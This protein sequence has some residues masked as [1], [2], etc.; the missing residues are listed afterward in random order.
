MKKKSKSKFNV[1]LLGLMFLL[2]AQ[3]TNAT[4]RR[5]HH[6]HHHPLPV[7]NPQPEPSPQP[8]SSPQPAVQPSNNIQC[9]IQD[10]G[11]I[12]DGGEVVEYGEGQK[13]KDQCFLEA[14]NFNGMYGKNIQLQASCGLKI[15]HYVDGSSGTNGTYAISIRFLLTQNNAKCSAQNAIGSASIQSRRYDKLSQCQREASNLSLQSNEQFAISAYCGRTVVNYVD[16]STGT[17]GTYKVYAT[18]VLNK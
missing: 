3:M 5:H 8:E 13:K 9:S 10:A 16:G 6:R 1:L 4:V 15:F 14:S 17:D 11:G 7:E 2:F 18:L 12:I